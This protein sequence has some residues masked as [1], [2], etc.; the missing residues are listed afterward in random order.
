MDASDNVDLPEWLTVAEAAKLLHMS[1]VGVCNA[2][3]GGRIAGE[4]GRGGR[5][6]IAR[7]EVARK[8]AE[9]TPRGYYTR[10]HAN[11]VELAG[12]RKFRMPDTGES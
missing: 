10:Q 12:G 8:L 1:H 7:S 6:R 2:L 3:V 11:T 9:D 4:K 5:W